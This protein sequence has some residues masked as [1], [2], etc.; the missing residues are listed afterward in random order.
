MKGGQDG[1]S[2]GSKARRAAGKKRGVLPEGFIPRHV[3]YGFSE[4]EK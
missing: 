1:W 4:T 3:L 2:E